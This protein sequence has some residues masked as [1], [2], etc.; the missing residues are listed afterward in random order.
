MKNILMQIDT[1]KV[2]ALQM[3]SSTFTYFWFWT[4]VTEFLIII[5]LILKLKRK[6]SALEFADLTSETLNSA[7]KTEINFDNLMNSIN[8][9]RDLYKEL[10]RVC[11]PDRFINTPKQKLA[12]EIFQE[13]SRHKRN[14]EKL[15]TLK[16]RAKAELNINL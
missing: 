14:H 5:F 9:S 1:L 3:D 2:S 6:Y 13:I 10:S 8:N 4:S 12:E 15:T 11:H 16:E 7:K